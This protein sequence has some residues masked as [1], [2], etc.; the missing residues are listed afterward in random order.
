MFTVLITVSGG[1][2]GGIQNEYFLIQY[3]LLVA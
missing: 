3:T 2:A 1:G